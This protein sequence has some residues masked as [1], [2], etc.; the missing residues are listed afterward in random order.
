[1]SRDSRNWIVRNFGKLSGKKCDCCSRRASQ[2][3]EW[4]QGI[5]I[6]RS[7][8]ASGAGAPRVVT[9]AVMARGY[10]LCM[11][12]SRQRWM[13]Y[14][15]LD[16]LIRCNSNSSER[17]L[18]CEFLERANNHYLMETSFNRKIQ[19][20]KSTHSNHF[21]TNYNYPMQYWLQS[22]YLR[23][24]YSIIKKG[25]NLY[26]TLFNRGN[27]PL[28]P[29]KNFNQN[30]FSVQIHGSL[31]PKR[32]MSVEVKYE[33]NSFSWSSRW[34]RCKT[35]RASLQTTLEQVE[36]LLKTTSG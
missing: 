1:M 14:N 32:A 6:N 34:T 35:W 26:W 18:S 8:L 22:K 19:I 36:T 24:A 5:I 16:G 27:L 15:K 12:C 21:R 30:N 13:D 28:F 29:N 17:E 4:K 7:S 11:L 2:R 31:E 25:V 9:R 23:I 20:L 33:H 10:Y 3:E